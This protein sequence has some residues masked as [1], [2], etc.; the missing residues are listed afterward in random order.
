MDREIVDLIEGYREYRASNKERN[1]ARAGVMAKPLV[2]ALEVALEQKMLEEVRRLAA[3]A[4]QIS[5]KLLELEDES[6]VPA[7]QD[8]LKGYDNDSSHLTW[9]DALRD[10][11]KVLKS[12]WLTEKTNGG[13]PKQIV[14]EILMEDFRIADKCRM[15]FMVEE[16]ALHCRPQRFFCGQ[17]S[18]CFCR[19]PGEHVSEP[20]CCH[21]GVF[22]SDLL[23]FW[24]GIGG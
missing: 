19:L 23:N 4:Q 8:L 24:G 5:R 18:K 9:T 22:G 12:E 20:I 13:Y 6:I 17:Y 1:W 15:L 3:P 10:A 21:T 11:I 2:L 16:I 14:S 7:I